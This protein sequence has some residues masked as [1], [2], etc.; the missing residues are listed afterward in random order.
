MSTARKPPPNQVTRMMLPSTVSCGWCAPN[1]HSRL[2]GSSCGTRQVATGTGWASS[3]MST[4]AAAEPA[5]RL[6]T[7]G[8]LPFH[9]PAGDRLGVRRVGEVEDH[10]D[11]ADKAVFLRRDVGVGAVRIETVRAQG[12][13]MPDRPRAGAVGDVVDLDAALEIIRTLA[14]RG[15]E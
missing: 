11:V 10:D 6:A 5:W 2:N 1:Q 15:T 14:G 13:V 7:F 12:F 8:P 3:V 9:P 4:L